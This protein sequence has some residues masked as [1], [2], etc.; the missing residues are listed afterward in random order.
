MKLKENAGI[1]LFAIVIIIMMILSFVK[2]IED[3]L[4]LSIT[5]LLFLVFTGIV[6]NKARKQ[7]VKFV[8]YVM[9]IF[10]II[11]LV[12]LVFSV[13]AYIIKRSTNVYKFQVVVEKENKEKTLLFNYDNHN[14]YVYNLSSVSIIMESTGE[15]HTL[16]EA[17]ET[18]DVTFDEILS[19]AAKDS[20]TTGY[21]I[22]YDAGQ[23]KYENSDYSIVVCDNEN[24]DVIFSTF[25]YKFNEEICK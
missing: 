19:L 22:Y 6:F 4:G 2:V 17:L 21:E 23:K 1:I 25:D 24:K 3:T 9:I 5:F 11:T 10:A 8:E 15:K 16:K 12:I 18:G 14:Y 20:N 7:D 13:R